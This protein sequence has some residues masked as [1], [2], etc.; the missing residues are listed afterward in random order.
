MLHGSIVF[1]PL[2]LLQH[3]EWT[4]AWYI[5]EVHRVNLSV[6]VRF[7]VGK[8]SW[9][10]PALSSVT[11]A[12]LAEGY[13]SPY[14]SSREC[15]GHGVKYQKNGEVLI[16]VKNSLIVLALVSC[17]FGC[18]GS[19]SSGGKDSTAGKGD[20][21][22]LISTPG[23]IDFGSVAVSHSKSQNGTLAAEGANV[24]VASASWNGGGFSLGGITFPVVVPVGQTVP[25]TVTFSPPTGGSSN[26]EVSFYS[27]ASYSPTVLALVG[28]GTTSSHSVSLSWD[29]STSQVAGYNIYRCAGPNGPF[30]KLNSLIITALS[31][32]DSAVQ[33]GATYYYTATSV[34]SN[35]VESPYSNTATAVIP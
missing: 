33:T 16:P 2:H 8:C 23:I 22:T 11:K 3:Y 6:T 29:A 25:F 5:S 1:D 12:R 18:G 32:S 28:N 4:C 35:N 15:L 14:S 10:L 24:T 9:A 26:G 13:N 19:T 20:S 30:Y 17:L 34:D 27:D 7:H 21:S 31:Y